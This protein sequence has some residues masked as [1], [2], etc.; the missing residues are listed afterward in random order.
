MVIQAKL[1]AQQAELVELVRIRFHH[2]TTQRDRPTGYPQDLVSAIVDALL[3]GVTIKALH[4]ASR[5]PEP[6]ARDVARRNGLTCKRGAG[7]Y[8]RSGAT[9]QVLAP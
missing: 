8:L 5:V 9:G 2:F 6:S 4:R 3:A 7:L 1:T